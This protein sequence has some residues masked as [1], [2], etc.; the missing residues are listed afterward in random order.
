[1]LHQSCVRTDLA[2]IDTEL[3]LVSVDS[4]PAPALIARWAID[5]QKILRV[6]YGPDPE[7]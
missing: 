1:M 2:A 7:R 3:V 4:F 6:F 5:S